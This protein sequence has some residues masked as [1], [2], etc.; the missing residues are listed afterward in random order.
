MSDYSEKLKDPRWQ[1]RRLEIMSRDGFSCVCCGRDDKTLN[2]HHCYYV[3]GR[4]PWDYPDSSLV[5]VCED[6]HASEH[7][8]RDIQA[9]KLIGALRSQGATWA[10]VGSLANIFS[11]SSIA[12]RQAL[13]TFIATISNIVM[14]SSYS[15][16]FSDELQRLIDSGFERAF[17]QKPDWKGDGA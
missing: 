4:E 16:G 12:D 14:L 8:N 11:D 17:P 6:C 1:R 7:S 2:V 3:R 15:D 9:S 13:V 5:T 10:E